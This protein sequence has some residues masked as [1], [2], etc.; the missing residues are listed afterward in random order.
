MA[1][2]PKCKNEY[3]EG[4]T[5]CADC[6]CALVDSLDNGKRS[7][8]YGSQEELQKISDF[9]TVNQVAKPDI[10]YNEKDCTYELQIMPSEKD[11]VSNAMK[12]YFSKILAAELEVASEVSE[13]SAI[14]ETKEEEVFTGVYEASDKK[15]EE[16]RTGAN[17]LLFVGGI[18]LL[19]LV[20][21]YFDIIPVG[22]SGYTKALITGVMGTLFIV[23]LILGITS[24]KSYQKLKVQGNEEQEKQDA[25]KKYLL[26][27]I[28]VEEFDAD[29][30]EEGLS[31]EILYFRRIDKL[32]QQIQAFDS[33]ISGAFLDYIIED[34]YTEIFEA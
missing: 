23:F 13:A 16:Y 2:C 18:G 30:V 27:T 20:L 15:A 25:V 17:T 19:A 14:E 26:E 24:R 8:Y 5:V 4:F 22:F 11:A 1:W 28:Q 10:I 7:V 33:S 31:D 29:L 32:K 12:I 6:G 3:R 21:I 34:C 9:L